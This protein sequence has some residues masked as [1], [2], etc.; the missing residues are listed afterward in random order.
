MV[1]IS[2]FLSTSLCS[3]VEP[4]FLLQFS[5]LQNTLRLLQA[6]AFVNF[7]APGKV[8]MKDALDAY[9]LPLSQGFYDFIV[10][11]SISAATFPLF[12][13]NLIT[14]IWQNPLFGKLTY[15]MK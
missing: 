4:A 7:F 6:V 9:N 11:L 12:Y 10:G 5:P 1:S 13:P 15:L 14:I 3:Q 2:A 8:E